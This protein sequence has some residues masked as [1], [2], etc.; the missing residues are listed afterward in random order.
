MGCIEQDIGKEA[1]ESVL[2]AALMR[3]LA[4]R[5]TAFC[6]TGETS[7]IDL[8]SLPMLPSD[9]D[10]LAER[11]GEG[12]VTATLSVAGDSEVR[13][14]GY[15]GVWWVRHLGGDGKLAAEQIEIASIPDILRAHCDDIALSAER[16]A[17]AFNTPIPERP[18][19]DPAHV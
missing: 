3:E 15:A 17:S 6:A 10:L 2:V 14:T 9:R 8:K 4:D 5:L 18:D 11:L 13:E 19:K 12:E 7:V 16:L 1:G